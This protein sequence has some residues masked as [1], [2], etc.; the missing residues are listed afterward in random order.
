MSTR[1]LPD[2]A[3]LEKDLNRYLLRRCD[4]PH[5]SARP[6]G[7]DGRRSAAWAA[8]C[9]EIHVCP[10]VSSQDLDPIEAVLRAW[11][12][13]RHYQVVR[14]TRA[15]WERSERAIEGAPVRRTLYRY[16]A[17][18]G[19]VMVYRLADPDW[20]T[21]SSAKDIYTRPMVWAL[22]ADPENGDQR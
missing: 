14:V 2:P 17:E 7:R 12:D 11:A 9:Y 3:Q 19:S 15:G 22:I 8:D 21:K 18:D 20:P 10:V 13:E 5:V 6:I 4:G 1:T 16:T